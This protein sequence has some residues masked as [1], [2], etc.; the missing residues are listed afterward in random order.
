MTTEDR[1]PKHARDRGDRSA[2]TRKA[3][4]PTERRTLCVQV[5]GSRPLCQEDGISKL[6]PPVC[7]VN[8][9][10]YQGVVKPN[11]L[12][13]LLTQCRHTFGRAFRGGVSFTRP[14]VRPGGRSRPRRAVNCESKLCLPRVM[15]QEAWYRGRGPVCVTAQAGC[16]ARASVARRSLAPFSRLCANL[17]RDAPLSFAQTAERALGAGDRGRARASLV[18]RL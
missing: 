10:C 15:A 13:L 18:R 1:K 3:R 2:T 6:V 17:Y 16:L 8:N 4:K 9:K 5:V 11:A 7:S 12:W 14:G